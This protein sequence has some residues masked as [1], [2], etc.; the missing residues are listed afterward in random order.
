[1]HAF[2]VHSVIPGKVF[3]L[4]LNLFLCSKCGTQPRN[5]CE[6]LRLFSGRGSLV[7][8]KIE[9]EAGV[10]W[11]KHFSLARLSERSDRR[12]GIHA[13]RLLRRV[14]QPTDGDCLR[15]LAF[16]RRSFSRERDRQ[17]GLIQACLRSTSVTQAKA[18]ATLSTCRAASGP[19]SCCLIAGPLSP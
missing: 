5:S 12:T 18:A 6:V 14:P 2:P 16:D 3:Y 10:F 9:R 19:A 4:P 17:S 11:A 13:S 15:R 1:M 8:E 7:S